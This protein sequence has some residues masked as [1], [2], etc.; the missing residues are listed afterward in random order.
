MTVNFINEIVW[1]YFAFKRKT[2]KNFPRKHDTILMYGKTRE[3]T[4]NVQYK[5]HKPEY[6]ARFKKDKDGRLY[7]DD[8]NPTGGGS[9]VIYLDDTPG[10][11]VD[12]VWDDIPPVNPVAKERYNYATQK[13]EGLLE[14]LINSTTEKGDLVA[15]FFCGSGT[16]AATAEK[17]KR[18]WIQCD[19]SRWAVQIT[20]KRILDI[21]NCRPFEVL[22]LGKYERQYWQGITFS[23]KSSSNQ[24]P[25]HEYVKFILDLY[26]AE[27]IT[28]MV[29][30]HGQRG[31]RMV[32]VGAID[33][34]V[35]LSEM[36]DAIAECSKIKQTKLDI[37]GWEWEMGLHDVEEAEAR[38]NGINLR[39][40]HIPREAMDSRAVEAGDIHFYELAYLEVESEIKE[41]SVRIKLKNFV[42][43][44][45]ELIPDEIRSKI[46]KWSDYIDYWAIDYEFKDDVFHNQWQDYRTRIKRDLELKS[47][48]HDYETPGERRIL[49]KV[50]DIFGNDTTHM[51][52]LKLR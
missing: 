19:M 5:P 1:H 13:P 7:R 46:K 6:V 8:V 39:L 23:K 52:E 29:H 33:A 34:P 26:K 43:P 2:A 4:W 44:S 12:S 38:K 42:I 41:R 36:R 17:L 50:F 32:H 48:W 28:G 3:H 18:N 27:P 45:P 10:D 9:R 30:I 20:R 24:T 47:D 31:G 35:T 15:D 11:I 22:N 14:R 51:L 49:V 25:L 16:T 40:V 37:L 21:N